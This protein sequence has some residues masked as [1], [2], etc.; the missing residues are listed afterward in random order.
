[1]NEHAVKSQTV[2]SQLTLVDVLITIAVGIVVAIGL[3][4]P[5]WPG[6]VGS[7]ADAAIPRA[8]VM[9]P[10]PTS[11]DD[12]GGATSLAAPPLSLAAAGPLLVDTVGPAAIAA[13]PLLASLQ[14]D[15]AAGDVAALAGRVAPGRATFEVWDLAEREEPL[16]G[17]Q[18][19]ATVLLDG[20]LAEADAAPRIMGWFRMPE[21]APDGPQRALAYGVVTCCWHRPGSDE[22]TPAGLVLVARGADVRLRQWLWLGAPGDGAT[23]DDLVQ[24][25]SASGAWEPEPAPDDPGP[26]HYTQVEWA[27]APTVAPTKGAR[28]E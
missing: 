13:V 4:H 10:T 1:M 2:P 3:D 18:I 16:V 8:T 19:A 27:T 6:A 28:A 20:L 23:V 14:A 9:A 26:V 7:P 5:V 22:V 21:P 25:W 24:A 15:L 12:V 17:D 11:A